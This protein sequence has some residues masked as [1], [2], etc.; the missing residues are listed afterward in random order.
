[1]RR[2]ALVLAFCFAISP[3]AATAATKVVKP[4]SHK[5]KVKGHKA[6]KAKKASKHPVV[7]HN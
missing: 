3:L 5:V 4:K 7:K 2:I 6:P 1:M